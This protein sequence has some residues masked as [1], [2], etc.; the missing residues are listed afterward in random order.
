MEVTQQASLKGGEFIIKPTDA[1]K[2]G[3]DPVDLRLKNA[4]REGSRRIDGPVFKRVGCIEVLEA[5]RRHEHYL[6]P[7]EPV[8]PTGAKRGRGVA[9]GY[10]FNIGLPSSCVI[11]VN[12]DGTSTAQHLVLLG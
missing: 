4:A 7:L 5:T 9:I 1:Q 12:D 2:L 3:I 6:A 8:G 10:W 11:S